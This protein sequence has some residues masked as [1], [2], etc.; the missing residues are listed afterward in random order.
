MLTRLTPCKLLVASPEHRE[1]IKSFSKNRLDTAP[2]QFWGIRSEEDKNYGEDVGEA[3][4]FI[5]GKYGAQQPYVVA[6]IYGQSQ[7]VKCTGI[8]HAMKILG[9]EVIFA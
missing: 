6:T 4:V 5:S 1:A 2:V 8:N 3:T 9:H 7:T